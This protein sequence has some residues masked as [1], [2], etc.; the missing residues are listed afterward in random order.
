MAEREIEFLIVGGGDAGFSAARTLREEGADGSVLV[1]SRDPDPPYDRTAVS[2]GYLGGEKPRSE[3]LLGGENWFT[4]NNVELLTRTSAMKLDT[5]AHSVT[6]SN[7]DVIRYGKLLLATG[8]NVRR[9]RIEGADLNGIHYLRALGN[10]DAIRDDAKG[11]VVLV[12]GSYIATEVAATLTSMGRKCSLVMLE[13]VTLERTF[14]KTAG[15]FFQ[16]ALTEHGVDVYPGEEVERFEGQ[17]RVSAVVTRSGKRIS[18]D[19]VIV[20]VGVTPDVSLAKKAGLELGEAGGVLTDAKL[21]TSAV[22]VFAAGD[23]A[24]YDSVVHGRRV[25]I[26]H[27]D[28][29]ENQGKTAARSML[30]HTDPH[31]VVPYFF[32]DLSDWTWFEYVGP[33]YTWTEEVVRGS[34]DEGQFTVWYL[35]GDRLAGALSVDRSDDLDRARELIKSR[36]PVDREELG[37]T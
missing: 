7:K 17:G 13:N 12:G 19:A 28:V 5:E 21:A 16:K 24:E 11:E 33:A 1:V 32:S 26:E 31:D 30:G 29:A 3:V 36:E 23:I 6:L 15:A 34:V 9:L 37:Q 18:A 27:W 14:G 4:E 20:G 10:A 25:R 22:D 2:K 35:D 8:A